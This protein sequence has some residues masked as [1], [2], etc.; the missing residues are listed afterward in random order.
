M[1]KKIINLFAI[2]LAAV[3]MAA[4]T[5]CSDNDEL[6][7][8]KY[9]YVQFKLYKSGAGESAAAK[10]TRATD[11]LEYLSDACK[12]KVLMNYGG[13]T[14]VQTLVLNAYNA[15]N[16]EY[17]LR[18]SKL[19]LLAGEY[20]LVGY[21]LY[22]EVDNEILS[23]D[24]SGCRFEVVPGGMAV[25]DI[26]VNTVERGL[27]SFKLVKEWADVTR[28][29]KDGEEYPFGNIKV[30]DI[31]VQN[32]F[33]R[34]TTT[35]KKVRVK[36]VADFGNGPVDDKLYPGQNREI[37]YALC[38]TVLWL[39]AG[40]YRV[41]SCVTYSD[42]NGKTR[43]AT[44]YN[45]TSN[46]FTVK[47]NVKT[48]DV[49]VPVNLSETAEY[50]KDY[51]A[52]KEIWEALDGPN[53][54]YAGEVEPQGVNWNFNKEMD[55]W[56]EQ[57]GVQLHADGRVATISLEGFG[58]KGVVPDAIG[59]LTELSIL[60]LGSHSDM[61][62][63]HIFGRI[64]PNMSAEEKKA[65]RMDYADKVLDRDFRLGL[66]ETWQKTIEAD[67]TQRPLKKG[68]SLKHIQFGDMTNGIEG[69]SR[70]LMRCTKLE[71][72]FIANCP[73]TH[74]G[75][76]RDI[77]PSSPFYEGRDTL[78]WENMTTLFDIEIFNCPKL[79]ALPMEMLASI[80]ELQMLNVA[81]CK[82][83]SGEQLKADWE[84]F[85]NGNSGDRIQ[86]IYMGFNNLKE[87]P[88]Y[89]ELKKMKNLGMI[90]CANNQIEKLNPFGK[91]INLAKVYLDYNKIKSI[92]V[93]PDGY[94]MGFTQLE[95]FTA[96]HNE[97]EL[98]PDIFNARSAYICQSVDFSYNK[99]RGF[100]NGDDF[101]GINAG[102]VN[103]SDNYLETFPSVLFKKG[104]PMNYLVLAG[105]G[106]KEI[107]EGALQ[108]PNTFML[109]ALDLSYNYLSKLPDDFYARTLPYLAGLDLSYN[110]FSEFPTKPLSING[111]S[112]FFIRYQRDK[113]GNR[114]LKEWPV[115]LY[116]C[117]AMTYFCIG[118]N[119]LRKIEDTIS[120]YIYY[121]EIAD[122]PNI[123]IDMS[124]VCDYIRAGYYTLIYDRTQDIRGCDAIVLDR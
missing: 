109:E 89:E 22:D 21:T 33:T 65:V 67:A 30:V 106:M 34:E 114:I 37:S 77:E 66:S 61:L 105:N 16:A 85:I 23:S 74:E 3:V 48:E 73:V 112:R 41:N 119:D 19:R 64:S 31:T 58:P 49:E 57:P 83:I 50:I 79:T 87:F 17:G 10:A 95:S 82:G 80:P 54:S 76:F 97:I 5:G 62:G 90:D 110:C 25:Q 56:G 81:C 69:V 18:S 1:D 4:F 7:R 100:E 20:T 116:T 46:T 121:F 55:L 35:I 63:G 45:T 113:D 101:K 120:P 44:E 88:E 39:K 71:Q 8:E 26:Y 115:G 104:S 43:L 84:A 107:P 11:K 117:P 51:I 108:G 91:E 9:G 38:D 6:V 122:N 12:I 96:T 29:A 94:F 92:P 59:Q 15:E 123:S 93:A 36:H 78:S 86:V 60:Y 124:G 28:A 14:I 24:V 103:I 42:K 52:L 102:Q 70:A 68:I 99:I 118:G 13:N 98:F 2:L 27:V 75:F 47:D 53:W 72:F 111:L 40:N 32:T